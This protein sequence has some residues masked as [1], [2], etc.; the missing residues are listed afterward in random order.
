MFITSLAIPSGIILIVFSVLLRVKDSPFKRA[1]R[2]LGLVFGL[3]ALL[4]LW[5]LLLYY[6]H[7]RKTLIL[8]KYYFPL[9]HVFILFIGPA[10]YAYV[11]ILF[12]PSRRISARRLVLHALPAL[13]AVV[14]TIY[15][16][17]LSLPMRVR[18]LTTEADPRRW[19][20][21]VFDSLFCVQCSSY[22]LVCFV[23]VNKYRKSN[24]MLK[25][26]EFQ[27]NLRWLHIFLVLS[28]AGLILYM[29]LNILQE[30]TVAQVGWGEV[31]IALSAIYLFIQ[32]V[33][34]TGLSMQHSVKIPRQT[35]RALQ[36][37]ENVFNDYLNTIIEIVEADK[38]YL[39]PE[40]SLQLVSIHTG[41]NQNYITHVINSRFNKNFSDFINEYRCQSARIL[42]ESSDYRHLTTEAIG[43]ECGF[44]NRASFH[45]AFQKMYG[46]SPHKY[47]KSRK[48][49][50]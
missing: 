37:D 23:K 21:L 19:L 50:K 36:L 45:L 32:S 8:L 34:A 42:L 28:L 43:E 15:F 7:S 29:P 25:V 13:P 20:D 1:N 30:R 24:Y 14:Y 9:E 38:L 11:L 16:A 46:T 40:C 18:M 17:T 22:F 47:H 39:K 2:F 35:G 12:D 5:M 4:S 10:L 33:I 44:G 31:F 48:T 27:A 41:I 3:F 6:V 49:K 26:K